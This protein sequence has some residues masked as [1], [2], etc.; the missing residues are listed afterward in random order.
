VAYLHRVE[1]AHGLPAGERQARVI[2]A[3]RRNYLDVLYRDYRTN[4]ELDGEAAHAF[5]ERFRDGRRD[6]AGVLDG[7]E[8]LRYGTSDVLRRP[9][10]IADEV[11]RVL[12]RNGWTT[13]PRRCPNPGCAIGAG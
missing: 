5:S 3:G 7:L 13:A 12:V 10:G 4:V 8:A 1:R 11:S 2:R 9:C 6:N